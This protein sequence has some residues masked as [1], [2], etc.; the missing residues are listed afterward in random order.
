MKV[1]AT[2]QG[3]YDNAIRNEGDEFTIVPVKYKVQGENKTLS[4]EDQFSKSWMVKLSKPGPK[5]KSV[6][7]PSAAPQSTSSDS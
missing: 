4:T 6:V 1:K 2:Q 3:F 7:E 5:A